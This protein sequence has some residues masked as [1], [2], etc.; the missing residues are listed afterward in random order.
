MLCSL[1]PFLDCSAEL[2]LASGVVAEWG[3]SPISKTTTKY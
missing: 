2:G 3:L 1:C